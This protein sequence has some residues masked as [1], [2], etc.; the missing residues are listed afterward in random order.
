MALFLQVDWVVYNS[1]SG[2]TSWFE[3]GFDRVYSGRV[4]LD[5]SMRQKASSYRG[6]VR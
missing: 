1:D 3:G 2:D 5:A 4:N 6:N